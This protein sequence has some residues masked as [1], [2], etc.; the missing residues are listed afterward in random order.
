MENMQNMPAKPNNYQH[1][2]DGALCAVDNTKM[3]TLDL[4]FIYNI[5]NSPKIS[6]SLFW[7]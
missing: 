2:T 4:V 7:S 3:K 6:V 5:L 1:C